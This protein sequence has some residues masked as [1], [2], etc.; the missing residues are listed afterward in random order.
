MGFRANETGPQPAQAARADQTVRVAAADL[1]GP[2]EAAELA[3]AGEEISDPD[4]RARAALRQTLHGVD[5]GASLR[6]AQFSR[7]EPGLLMTTD[8]A[9]AARARVT[10]GA[11]PSKQP[12]VS[13]AH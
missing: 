5:D 2:A 6:R 4:C 13:P 9:S 1:E 3:R 11:L 12:P 8:A 10:P 7:G